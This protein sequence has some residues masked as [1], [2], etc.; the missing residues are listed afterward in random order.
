M[1]EPLE[2]DG[3][4]HVT[5]DDPE[6]SEHAVVAAIE[7]LFTGLRMGLPSLKVRCCRCDTQ[8]GEG[9]EVSVYAYRT[10]ETPRWH[11]A[12]CRCLDCA[13]DDIATPTLGATEVRISARLGVISD[14]GTQQHQL[15]L[16]EPAIIAVTPPEGGTPP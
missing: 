15:C 14:V 7:Q 1:M 4:L 16:V 8:L 10:V 6:V 13:P 3:S 9:D 2:T 11:L 12:R 5:R